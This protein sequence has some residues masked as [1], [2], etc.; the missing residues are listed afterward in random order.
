M[1]FPSF[2]EWILMKE[3][4]KE[5]L[6]DRQAMN[7]FLNGKTNKVKLPKDPVAIGHQAHQSGTGAWKNKKAYNRKKNW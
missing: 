4:K 6:E 7:N 2:N 3:G 5:S 1:K